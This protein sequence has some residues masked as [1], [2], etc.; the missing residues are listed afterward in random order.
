MPGTPVSLAE[1][2]QTGIEAS[3]SEL[4]VARPGKVT[5]YDPITNTAVVKPMV[6]NAIYSV[7]DDERSYEE[8]PEIPFVPVIWPRAGSY[9]VTMPLSVG[10]TVLLV[11]CDASMAEWLETGTLGEPRDARRHSI[12]WPV[13]FPGL[14]PEVDPLS[15]S[16]LDLA[17]RAA[18]MIVGEHGGVGRIEITPTMIKIGSTAIDFVALSTP[19]NAAI[20]ACM[21]AANAAIAAVTSVITAVNAHTH[22][23]TGAATTGNVFPAPLPS[24]PSAGVTPPTVAAVLTKAQ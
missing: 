9:V 24:A 4:N 17:A 5:A 21:A 19:T 10:D 12:G 7:E 11:F 6:K 8:L 22:A 15:P 18:G 16:P 1:T 23:V 2:I 13:A 20:A 14:C 3:I